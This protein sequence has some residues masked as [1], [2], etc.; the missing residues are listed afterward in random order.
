MN[1]L[2]SNIPKQTRDFL[3]HMAPLL[4]ARRK[5]REEKGDNYD[6]PV[7]LILGRCNSRQKLINSMQV[8]LVTWLMDE[9]E[10]KET[11]DWYFTLRI[12]T[13]NFVAIHTSSMVCC[14]HTHG[15]N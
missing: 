10:G 6:K 2:F 3:N 4:A 1:K 13:A 15:S 9:A 14:V 11:T 5:E 12:M 8:D 7:W